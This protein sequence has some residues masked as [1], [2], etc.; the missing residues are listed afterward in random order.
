MLIMRLLKQRERLLMVLQR[1]AGLFDIHM[2]V[3][4]AVEAMSEGDRIV[5]VACQGKCLLIISASLGVIAPCPQRAKRNKTLPLSMRVMDRAG[6]LQ[7]MLIVAT[8]VF[9]F[10]KDLKGL[11][12][13]LVDLWRGTY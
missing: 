4:Q 11:P 13:G 6:Y 3:S 1:F 12:T 7:S 10:A 8:C 9:K 5:Q 2:P